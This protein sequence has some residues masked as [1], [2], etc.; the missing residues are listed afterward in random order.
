[1]S[2]SMSAKKACGGGEHDLQ[3]G[4]E[5]VGD[6]DPV[7]DQVT[8]GTNRGPQRGGLLGVPF[9]WAESAPVGAHHVG[10][11]HVGQHVCVEPVVVVAGGPVPTAQVLH[12]GGWDDQDGQPRTEQ[13]VDDLAV[14]SFDTDLS[15]LP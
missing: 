4:A 8:A 14:G 13:G 2:E 5:L 1:M 15:D 3:M 9:Q 10:Q 7:G 6:G 12:L 11:H